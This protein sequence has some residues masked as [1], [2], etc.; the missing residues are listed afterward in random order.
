MIL[1]ICGVSHYLK[2]ALEALDCTLYADE[3]ALK[4]HLFY[5]LYKDEIIGFHQTT[6]SKSILNF[7]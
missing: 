7:I 5:I 3:M 4:T 1:E 6:S 2:T